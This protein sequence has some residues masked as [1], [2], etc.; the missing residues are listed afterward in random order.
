MTDPTATPTTPAPTHI[1]RDLDAPAT[2]PFLGP[3]T[4]TLIT[5]P[6]AFIARI[7][8]ILGVTSGEDHGGISADV[9][10]TLYQ[11]ALL[12][13]LSLLFAA[14]AL[15]RTERY[16]PRRILF[17]ALAPIGVVVLS[18]ATLALAG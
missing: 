4:S 18:V 16:S 13:L 12:V 2:L 14:F 7:F 11:I 17:S 6:L 1:P 9:V 8:V 3:V 5:L 15:P 10:L